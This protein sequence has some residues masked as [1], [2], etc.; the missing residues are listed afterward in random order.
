MSLGYTAAAY[1]TVFGVAQ[2]FDEKVN[3]ELKE[4]FFSLNIDED[5]STSCLKVLAVLASYFNME[6]GEIEV[7]HIGAVSLTT[8]TAKAIKDKL[9]EL[10]LNKG[11]PWSNCLSLLL[12]SCNV[13]RGS[14]GGLE[15]HTKRLQ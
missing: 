11:L 8:V 9:V 6:R 5:T 10:F 1:K 4:T 15:T 7:H 2:T 14:K 12:D 13:M 3:A